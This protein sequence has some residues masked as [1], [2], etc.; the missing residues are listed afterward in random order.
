MLYWIGVVGF[1]WLFGS[2]RG[3]RSVGFD[4]TLR[5]ICVT[6]LLTPAVGVLV[7]EIAGWFATGGTLDA[8]HG[9]IARARTGLWVGYGVGSVSVLWGRLLARSNVTPPAVRGQDRSDP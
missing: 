2:W 3:G 5:A 9:I 1:A 8:S 4:A 7:W 6:A